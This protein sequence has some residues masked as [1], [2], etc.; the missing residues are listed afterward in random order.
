MNI[1]R[2]SSEHCQ[3]VPFLTIGISTPILDD[4]QEISLREITRFRCKFTVKPAGFTRFS[5][6]P[7]PVESVLLLPVGVWPQ[8][9]GR[10]AAE[11]PAAQGC[12]LKEATPGKSHLG[13]FVPQYCRLE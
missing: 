13:W 9:V 6:C 7:S 10:A 11:Q 1:A 8:K 4:L 3:C 2:G 5:A 12:A